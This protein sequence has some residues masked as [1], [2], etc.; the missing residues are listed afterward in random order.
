MNSIV[1]VEIPT[2][3]FKK[4]KNFFGKVFGWTF[5]D[6]PDMKYVI[7]QAPAPPHGGFY[8]VQSMPKKGQVNIY[9]DVDD[10]D[11]KLKE[12]RKARGKVIRKKTAIGTMGWSAQF[13]T[14]DGCSLYLF[15]N[16]PT[17]Q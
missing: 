15:Q 16:A 5:Q 1:H 7:F 17:A 4:A 10:I 2:T 6:F 3:D 13:T 11:V 14:P 12:I 8:L 9:L